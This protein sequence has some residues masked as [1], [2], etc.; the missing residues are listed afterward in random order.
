MPAEAAIP[1]GLFGAAFGLTA[2]FVARRW[3]AHEPDYRPRP[4]VDWRTLILV[5][6]G[7]AV[8][9][10][11]YIRWGG[12]MAYV[13]VLAPYLAALLVLL[14]TDLDQRI[15]PDL[16]TLPLIA[17]STALLVLGWSPL[18]IGK[19]LGLVSGLIAGIGAPAI[20]WLSDRILHGDLGAG[21]L[22]LAVSVGFMSGI[23]QLIYGVLVAS[24]AFSAVLI[25]LIAIRRLSLKSAVPFGP[26]LIF[27]AYLAVLLG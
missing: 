14:A 17:Y 9:F 23:S 7:A 1:F 22:K 4:T 2:D 18:L 3:P 15:L 11:F 12:V 16:V 10:G 19:D 20:L 13:V 24:V 8:F 5:L 21:D 25:A 6:T 27:G 26:V